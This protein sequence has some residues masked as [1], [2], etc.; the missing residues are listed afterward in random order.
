[1]AA[2]LLE[3]DHRRKADIGNSRSRS[4]GLRHGADDFELNKPNSSA[5]ANLHSSRFRA[6]QT[7]LAG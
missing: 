2:I 4:A 5:C 1:M 6:L 3:G 7:Q